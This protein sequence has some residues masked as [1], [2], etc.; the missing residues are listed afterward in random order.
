MGWLGE[1]CGI[2]PLFHEG[3]ETRMGH[4]G[5]LRIAGTV[6]AGWVRVF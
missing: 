3:R 1:S 6:W 5:V 2:P 4:P